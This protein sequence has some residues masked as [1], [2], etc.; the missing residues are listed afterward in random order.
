VKRSGEQAGSE[1]GAPPFR[2][3]QA[4]LF[5][6][7]DFGC[8]L[9][10][11]SATLY[12]LFYDT[13]YL[14]IPPHA[15]G[16][17]Y[18]AGLSWDGVAGLLIGIFAD[19]AR[20][21]GTPLRSWMRLSTIPLALSF[22]LIYWAPPASGLPLLLLVLA[23]HLVFRTLYAAVNVPYVALLAR[24]ARTSGER[25]RIAG[26]R[27]IFGAAAAAL[28]A[29]GTQRI[30]AAGGAQS[31]FFVAALFF[32]A[33][34]S[35]VLLWVGS[36][37]LPHPTIRA[38][39]DGTRAA[40][41]GWRLNPAFV[42]LN[43][44]M[45]AAVIATTMVG[46]STLY[47]FK[48]QIHDEHAAGAALA[49]MGVVGVLF[50]PVWMAVAVRW[51]ARAQWFASVATAAAALALFMTTSPRTATRMDMF[52][53]L[54]QASVSGFSFG[55]WAMLPDAIEHRSEAPADAQALMFGLAALL[56]KIGLGI[57][58]ALVGA[59]LAFSGYK[60][61]AVQSAGTLLSLRAAMSL[62]PLAALAVSAAA[63][64]FNPLRPER[65]G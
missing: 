22:L 49:L 50:V 28:V 17:I 40:A 18:L 24:V 26:L 46:K 59:L 4:I 37:K 65:G 14:Q 45:I 16:L 39:S 19:R 13:D 51:G 8:N 41:A 3:R 38:G 57:A 61:N 63:M 2:W 35:F 1:E 47:Y 48:Y 5:A 9:Y 21:G 56:Q 34:A 31:G 6:S 25:S 58:A 52:L 7:G 27:M 62:F 20:G 23:F 15:A 11:Q 36:A 60:A 53:A 64:A 33:L 43:L 12:L 55:F 32:S 10:W 29:I 30:G 44:A 54:F 42:T